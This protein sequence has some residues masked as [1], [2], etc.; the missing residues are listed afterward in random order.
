MIESDY[1]LIE[2]F[3][4]GQLS[5]EQREALEQRLTQDAVLANALASARRQR[6]LRQAA[7]ELYRPT[8]IEA[9][10]LTRTTME[11][12]YKDEFAPLAK[13]DRRYLV[14]R[15]TRRITAV[16]ACLFLA[17]GSYWLGYNSQKNPVNG[18]QVIINTDAGQTVRQ[19]STLDEA[20]QYANTYQTT[21]MVTDQTNGDNQSQLSTAGEF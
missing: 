12:C 13:L 8:D 18:Y 19:F 1:M 2:E 14:L 10:V 21:Q 20:K 6:Q 3:L 5:K 4:D 9:S 17:A 7:V 11:R 16:A 15:W